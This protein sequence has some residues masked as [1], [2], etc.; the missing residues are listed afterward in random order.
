MVDHTLGGGTNLYREQRILQQTNAGGAV[1]LLSYDFHRLRYFLGY[2]TR[3]RRESFETGL[4]R[5]PSS[6]WWPP[7]PSTRSSSTMSA[8]SRIADDRRPHRAPHARLTQ[9][10]LTVAVLTSSASVHS[11]ESAE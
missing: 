8:R 5:R 1:I 10:R 11:M 3:E 9:A 7:S 6:S 4:R 2:V